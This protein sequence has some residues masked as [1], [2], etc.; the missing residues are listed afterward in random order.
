MSLMLEIKDLHVSVQGKEIVKGL[1]LQIPK[2]EIHAIMGPNGSGKS[3]LSYTILGHP[4]Y[5]ITKGDILLDGRSVLDMPTDERARAGLFLSLQ[6][7]TSIP[8]VTQTNF[9]R[10]VLKNIRGADVPVKD[11]RKELKEAMG[12]LDIDNSFMSRYVNDGFSGGEK[13]RNE[14]LQM[15]MIKPKMAILDEIDSGLD[16]DALRIIAE[17]IESMRGDD[18]SMLI[19]THYQRVLN[20]LTLDR[21]HIFMEGRIQK[22]GGRDLAERLEAEGYDWVL[23]KAAGA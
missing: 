20:Y 15:S 17:G 1:N 2:G 3:T 13:K 7:P 19:I 8:G 12:A 6:Y 21:V 23:E 16:I 9:L 14:I 10:N 11:F 5:E 4:N 22:S 18:R